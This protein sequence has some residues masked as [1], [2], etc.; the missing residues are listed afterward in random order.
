MPQRRKGIELKTTFSDLGSESLLHVCS[1]AALSLMNPHVSITPTEDLYASL[2]KHGNQGVPL[3]R[4]VPLEDLDQWHISP[5]SRNIRHASGRFFSVKGLRAHHANGPVKQW[6]Q[7]IIHQPE[8]GILGILIKEFDGVPHCLMQAKAEPG[9]YNGAQLSPTVQAT[10]S[11]YTRVHRGRA[12][13]YLD[14]FRHAEKYDVITDVLQSEQG[15]WFCR[16]RNRNIIVRVREEEEVELLDGFHWASVGQLHLLLS[17]PDLVNMDARTVMA[18]LPISFP[19]PVTEEAAKGAE[20]DTLRASVIHSTDTVAAQPASHRPQLLHWITDARAREDIHVETIPVNEVQDWEY[21]DGVLRH[22]HG[23]HFEIIGVDVRLDG[24]EVQQWSQPLLHPYGQGVAAFLVR[25]VDGA[26]QVLV[27]TRVEPGFLDLL[28][29]GPTVQ[30]TA[31]NYEH[32]GAK[33]RP[34]FLDTVLSATPETTHFDTVLSEEG[35]RFHHARTRYMVVEAD[36]GTGVAQDPD[37]RWLTLGELSAL[38]QYSGYVNV[39]ARTLIA[40]VRSLISLS[41]RSQQR[42]A[43]A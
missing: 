35:G 11:N 12:V 31:E 32:L 37:Y 30:C 29:L 28:E 4:Q 43:K 8:I 17:E 33:W 39:E 2:D 19:R 13:P 20:A 15:T 34:K 7:P 36:P 40:C 1:N 38:A 16:K 24:R 21:A 25:R 14:Y 22:T 41:Y 42:P 9:N 18:C 23:R 5:G 26:L 3:G 27:H 6:T 10:R